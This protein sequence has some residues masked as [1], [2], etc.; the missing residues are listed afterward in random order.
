MAHNRICKLLG[1]RYPIIQAPM[2]WASGAAL[3]AAVSAAGGMGTLGPNAGAERINPDVE[4][5][6]EL[7]RRQGSIF[8]RAGSRSIMQRR[9]SIYGL[10]R[11]KGFTYSCLR[12]RGIVYQ[13]VG[14]NLAF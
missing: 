2:S 6:G 12:Y 10:D 9:R 14:N 13:I 8:N 3:T 7:M 1:I 4:A 11:G 5:T